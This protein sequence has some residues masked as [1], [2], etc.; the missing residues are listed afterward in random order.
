MGSDV[1]SQHPRFLI[2]HLCMAR[3]VI[4]DPRLSLQ[5]QIA[6]LTLNWLS[7]PCIHAARSLVS[8]TAFL[9]GIM[10]HVISQLG[11]LVIHSAGKVTWSAD[12]VT[13]SAWE[14]CS[15]DQHSVLPY[16]KPHQLTGALSLGCTGCAPLLEN[17]INW[18]APQPLTHTGVSKGSQVLQRLGTCPTFN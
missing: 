15:L 3:G 18:G 14:P 2:C 10:H 17:L 8:W 7:A 16:W 9:A 4:V 1:G 5:Q 6:S 11:S 13:W 12:Q